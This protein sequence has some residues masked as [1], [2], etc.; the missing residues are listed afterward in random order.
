MWGRGGDGGNEG[1]SKGEAPYSKTLPCLGK[2]LDMPCQGL[3][4]GP[5]LRESPLP[6]PS[7]ALVRPS[8]KSLHMAET[9]VGILEP[10]TWASG[11]THESEEHSFLLPFVWKG[12]GQADL[13]SVP[14]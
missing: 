3:A 13:V 10:W 14:R 8:S 7:P 4:I 5:G 12:R 1:L 9:K 6:C 11:L 2:G